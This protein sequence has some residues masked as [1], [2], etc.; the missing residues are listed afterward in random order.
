MEFRPSIGRWDAF[1]LQREPYQARIWGFGAALGSQVT[2][3]RKKK[4]GKKEILAYT[5]VNS[6]NRS[7]FWSVDLPP[8]P[9]EAGHTLYIRDR[10]SN[11]TLRID[12]VAFGDVF[13]CSGQSNMEFRIE[14][15]FDG[16]EAIADSIN[17]PNLRVASIN[18][19]LASTPQRDV[20]SKTSAYIW[21][22][23][24]PES[25]YQPDP[26]GRWVAF[27]AVCYYFGRDL[28]KAQN[29]QVPIGL[30]TAVRPG[31][32]IEVFSSPDALMDPS[33]GGTRNISNSQSQSYNDTRPTAWTKNQ[34]A[35]WN[36]MIHPLLPMR[37]S[38]IVWYQGESNTD[39]PSTYACRFPSMITDWRR[40]FGV[41][42]LPFVYVEL[43][44][45]DWSSL[46]K[47]RAA[48]ASAL[49][50]TGVGRATAIDLSDAT[51]PFSP[52]HSRRKREVGRRVFLSMQN[53][54]LSTSNSKSLDSGPVLRSVVIRKRKASVTA[55]IRFQPQTR[56]NLHMAGTPNCVRCCINEPPFEVFTVRR[57]WERVSSAEIRNKTRVF[58]TVANEPN[59]YGIRYAWEGRPECALYNGE[60]GPDDHAGLPSAPFHWCANY[61]GEPFWSKKESCWVPRKP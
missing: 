16:E 56:P 21:A 50:L 48:Q 28:Y 34:S 9:A 30:I 29:G 3:R 35:I 33:C 61:T 42:D 37:L 39:D 19:T 54:L 32:K 7:G 40:K 13:L 14:S 57:T 53:L 17:Y 46:P 49:Q 5:I 27:S 41:P 11:T 24:S 10:S 22:A 18:T 45:V 25:L 52:S 59:I 26:K 1:V 44:A 4:D 2:V 12:D 36:G 23:S 31:T 20:G 15:N 55:T 47:F 43:A 6:T 38:G 60:G 58:S 8:Q 51:S